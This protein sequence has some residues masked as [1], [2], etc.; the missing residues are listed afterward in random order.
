MLARIFAASLLTIATAAAAA[1]PDYS[2]VELFPSQ[3]MSRA[4]SVSNTGIVVGCHGSPEVAFMWQNGVATDLFPGCA[5]S[6]NDNGMVGGY[7][8]SRNAV[9]WDHGTLISLG[10]PGQVN[11]ISNSGWAVIG[12]IRSMPIVYSKD[13]LYR[14]GQLMEMPAGC[15][16]RINNLNQILCPGAIRNPDGSMIAMP[17][18]SYPSGFDYSS[19]PGAAGLTD[20]A[21][22]VGEG[23]GLVYYANGVTTQVPRTYSDGLAKDLNSWPLMLGDEEGFYGYIATLQGEVKFLYQIP[24]MAGWGHPTGQKINESGWIAGSAAHGPT[25]GFE[26]AFVLIPKAAPPAPVPG[27]PVAGLPVMRQPRMDTNADG[28]GDLI[29]RSASGDFGVWQ[30][31]GAGINGARMIAAPNNA[32]L[33]FRADLDG[34]YKGD[35]LWQAPDGAY[36]ATMMDYT[37]SSATKLLD[38]GTGW[39]LVG[40]GDFD[41]DHMVDLLWA[42]PTQGFGVWLMN[43]ATV[44]SAGAIPY[45]ANA[46]PA[47]IGDFT[48]DGRDDIAW[49]GDDGHVELYTMN[50]LA[51]TAAGT[52]LEAGSGFVPAFIADFNGDNRA[53]IVWAHPDGRTSLWLM[54][55]ATVLG[56]TAIVGAGSG[57]HVIGT[58]D[59]N[60]DGMADLLF[61]ADDGSIGGWLMQGTTQNGARLFLGGGSGWDVLMDVE[62]SGDYKADLVWKCVDGSYGVWLMNGLGPTTTKV[63]LNGGSGWDIVAK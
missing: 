32:R 11:G 12:Y 41:G 3:E 27:H 26:E 33:L 31:D 48:N 47:A 4:N 9:I 7:D 25:S 34:N 51:G 40:A 24:A 37:T 35:L 56:S 28:R 59:F 14:D 43:G 29:L 53:D 22:A 21:Q 52:I 42:H 45:P 44:K 54:D 58:P 62:I 10:I 5:T 60:G 36:W 49:I 8:P 13:Y 18:T 38:G 50:G 20:N 6:V 39:T 23:R 30:M 61:R 15:S 16:I 57:W 55:G 19:F 17:G 63:M 2:V 46:W 1:I